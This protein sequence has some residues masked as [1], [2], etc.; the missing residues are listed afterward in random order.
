MGDRH[1][2]PRFKLTNGRPCMGGR[3]I[4]YRFL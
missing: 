1:K 4:G 2:S 3:D